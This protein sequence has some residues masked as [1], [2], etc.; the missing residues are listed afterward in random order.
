MCFLVKEVVC[1]TKGGVLLTE[2]HK[3]IR[4]GN[5]IAVDPT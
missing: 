2:E 1:L 5:N 4:L 3:Y